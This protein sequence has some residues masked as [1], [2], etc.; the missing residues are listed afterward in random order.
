MIECRVPAL[1][2]SNFIIRCGE[3]PLRSFLTPDLEGE[4]NY[5]GNQNGGNCNET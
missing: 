3:M 1:C 5:Q 4:H 2:V